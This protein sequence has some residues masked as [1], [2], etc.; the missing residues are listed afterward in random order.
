MGGCILLVSSYLSMAACMD[1][2]AF[3]SLCQQLATCLY[4]RQN[5]FQS[6]DDHAELL[7]SSCQHLPAAMCVSDCEWSKWSSD[8]RQQHT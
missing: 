5:I 2:L 4:V 3:S 6:R 8:K 7:A 1:S